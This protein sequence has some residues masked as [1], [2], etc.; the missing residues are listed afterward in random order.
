MFA[1]YDN[2]NMI[3]RNTAENISKYNSITSPENVALSPDEEMPYDDYLNKKKQS[4]QKALNSYK[5]MAN[6]DT[7]EPIYH[8]KDIMTKNPITININDTLQESYEILD[9]YKISHI[10]LLTTNHKIVGLVH[11]KMVLDLLI[12]EGK[13]VLSRH[14]NTFTFNETFTTDPLSDIRRV[15]QVMIQFKINAMPV[16]DDEGILQGIVSKTDIINAVSH[17]PHFQLWS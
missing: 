9:K 14:M 5:K 13:T 2:G 10:P 3:F 1:I 11:N 7:S 12:K 17:I 8:V 6:M 16:V 15:A 4:E